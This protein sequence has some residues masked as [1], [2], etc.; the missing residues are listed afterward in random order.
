VLGCKADGVWSAI[1]A[2]CILAGAR[3]LAGALVPLVGPDPNSFYFVA[4][5]YNRKTGLK[6]NG[7]NQYIDT[8]YKISYSSTGE[9]LHLGLVGSESLNTGRPLGVYRHSTYT[10][11][12]LPVDTNGSRTGWGSPT[13][14]TNEASGHYISTRQTGQSPVRY[15]NGQFNLALNTDNSQPSDWSVT[16][17]VAHGSANGVSTDTETFNSYSSARLQMYHIGDGLSA[18]QVANLSSRVTDLI[19]AIGVAIP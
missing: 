2:S 3:T 6:G 18:L 11:H 10:R 4:G 19:N 17:F 5:N 14:S 8:N 12:Y 9:N 13:N 7:S 15:Y 16:A 1:K